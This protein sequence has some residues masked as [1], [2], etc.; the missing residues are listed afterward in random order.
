[1]VW[2]EVWGDNGS[3]NAEFEV[4]PRIG[5]RIVIFADGVTAVNSIVEGVVHVSL[6]VH[7]K[8]ARPSIQLWVKN[9]PRP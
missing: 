7:G 3:V 5:E 8:E 2:C 6:A 4:L 9:A 1:M